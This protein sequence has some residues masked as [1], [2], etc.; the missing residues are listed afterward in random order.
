MFIGNAYSNNE[1]DSPT[2]YCWIDACGAKA[3][4]IKLW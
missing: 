4:W 3:C 1:G 2:P